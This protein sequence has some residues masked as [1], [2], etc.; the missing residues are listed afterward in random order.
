MTKIPSRSTTPAVSKPE[1]SRKQQRKSLP[2]PSTAPTAPEA[3]AGKGKGKEKEKEQQQEQEPKQE[4]VQ[5][6]DQDQDQ[7]PE[8]PEEQYPK[9]LIKT[10]YDNDPL[11][12][13]YIPSAPSE[14]I[15]QMLLAEPPLTYN[16]ARAGPSTSGK[17]PRY[18]C[19]ICGY[20]GK[21]RCRNCGVR[22]CGLDC[23]KIHEDSRCGAFF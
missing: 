19:T 17:S 12:R 3:P 5:A 23:Y 6:Q 21:I 20:W 14:R 22:T 16:A 1:Q 10:E 11:L 8:D 4:H 13:S 2:P 18:F 7:Q 15:M 9:G